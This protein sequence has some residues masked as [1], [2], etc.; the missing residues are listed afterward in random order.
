M[1]DRKLCGNVALITH[2]SNHKDNGTHTHI[3]TR[4]RTDRKRNFGSKYFGIF[5][6]THTDTHTLQ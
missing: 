1:R 2:Y 4:T 5:S 6:L 3:L